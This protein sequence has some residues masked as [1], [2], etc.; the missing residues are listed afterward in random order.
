M[1]RCDRAAKLPLLKSARQVDVYS[2]E[3]FLSPNRER[4]I[5]RLLISSGEKENKKEGKIAGWR[6]FVSPLAFVDTSV[7]TISH[8]GY[9]RRPIKNV[10]ADQLHITHPAFPVLPA[11]MYI[12]VYLSARVLSARPHSTPVLTF[13]LPFGSRGSLFQHSPVHIHVFSDALARSR[14]QDFSALVWHGVHTLAP[15]CPAVVRVLIRTRADTYTYTS[16]LQGSCIR[17]LLFG[18]AWVVEG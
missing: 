9:A 14:T 10:Q 2:K 6:K 4:W 7:T 11:S 13:S 8:R 1:K 17:V 15:A 16:P 3:I 18:P 5:P 12:Y